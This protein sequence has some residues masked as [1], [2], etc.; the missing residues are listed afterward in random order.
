MNRPLGS[1]DIRKALEQRSSNLAPG[2]ASLRGVF[3]LAVGS[4]VLLGQTTIGV[5][6][7]LRWIAVDSCHNLFNDE[8]SQH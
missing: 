6:W 3:Q 4:L 8:L 1:D 2:G 7:T 5:R